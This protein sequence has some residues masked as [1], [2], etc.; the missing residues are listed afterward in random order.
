MAK[1]PVSFINLTCSRLFSV[2][3]WVSI[4]FDIAQSQ[5]LA[6]IVW[7]C[8]AWA[9]TVQCHQCWL[10][11]MKTLLSVGCLTSL[12]NEAMV[13]N[14]GTYWPT[15]WPCCNAFLGLCNDTNDH[16]R[17]NCMKVLETFDRAI[18]LLTSLCQKEVSRFFSFCNVFCGYF[19]PLSCHAQDNQE[20]KNW[21]ISL[22]RVLFLVNWI[23]EES[24]KLFAVFP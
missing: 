11:L 24:D 2:S 19:W 21:M 20:E 13:P 22:S 6:F 17:T 23:Y 8:W 1:W 16:T 9:V 18:A 7:Q 15:Y 3:D 5:L 4:R 14:D 12:I 10:I